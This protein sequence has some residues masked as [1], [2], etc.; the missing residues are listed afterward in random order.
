MGTLNLPGILVFSAV[1]VAVM[2]LA[3]DRPDQWGIRRLFV[4]VS[5]CLAAVAVRLLSPSVLW[6]GVLFV[7]MYQVYFGWGYVRRRQRLTRDRVAYLESSSAIL[8]CLALADSSIDPRELA[9][10]RESYQRAGCSSE[11][12]D[13]V[14]SA[15]R[16]CAKQFLGREGEKLSKAVSE[17]CEVLLRHS[18]PQSRRDLLRLALLIT[19]GDGSF[20][21]AE[22]ESLAALAQGLQ[23]A[24]DEVE[25]MWSSLFSEKA[26]SSGVEEAR[27]RGALPDLGDCGAEGHQASAPA[28]LPIVVADDAEALSRLNH[29]AGGA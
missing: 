3:A 17:R 8:A 26:R 11:E 24:P 18:T 29:R 22:Q 23:I 15:I 13:I 20:T 14:E 1:A 21:G 4:G 5:A 12:L 9:V 7:G 25:K 28:R 16:E 19:V 2:A 6:F 27:A 10:I